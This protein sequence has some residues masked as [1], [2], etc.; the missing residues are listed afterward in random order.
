MASLGVE[1][2][3]KRINRKRQTSSFNCDSSSS[4]DTAA[5]YG[6]RAKKYHHFKY[7][8]VISKW[9]TK[10]LEDYGIAYDNNPISMEE[11]T[12]KIQSRA[13]GVCDK[14]VP[15]FLSTLKL[16]CRRGLIFS[17]EVPENETL[18]SF[19][20]LSDS[21]TRVREILNDFDAFVNDILIKEEEYLGKEWQNKALFFAWSHNVRSFINYY[22]KFL[23]KMNSSLSES[24]L[25]KPVRE[26]YMKELFMVF[27]KIFFLEP[28]YVPHFWTL[29][30]WS[31]FIMV[32]LCWNL[33]FWSLFIMFT[34]INKLQR[35]V[36]LMLTEVK[37][38]EQLPENESPELRKANA[39]GES[40]S[41][42]DQISGKFILNILSS[43]VLGQHG[44]ELL[45][46]LRSSAFAPAMVVGCICKGT[47]II[48]TFMEMMQNHLNKIV[49]DGKCEGESSI[50]RYT[51]PLNY[52]LVEERNKCL[53]LL[54]LLGFIQTCWYE[55]LYP[56]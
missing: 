37:K 44:G 25:A 49:Y 7:P 53:D 42:S 1:K 16:L 27:S 21:A 26:A 32:L 22:K 12:T 41:D 47:E 34:C 13:Q 51:N 9:T 4:S 5:N 24:W 17:L 11:F 29:G 14:K 30:Y 6:A 31:L 55:A 8:N 23:D 2:L 28:E 10:T 56:K 45:S 19:D 35:S 48:F 33:G 52:L 54:L 39:T 3:Q 46:E 36:L 43:N 38:V 20:V 18:K 15:D 50:I 40:S